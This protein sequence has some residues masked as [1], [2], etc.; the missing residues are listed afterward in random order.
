MPCTVGLI[1]YRK[2]KLKYKP[3][4]VLFDSGT[5][6]SIVLKEFVSKLQLSKDSRVEWETKGG[7]FI[8]EGTCTTTFSFPEFKNWKGIEWQLHVDSMTKAKDS[9]YDMIIGGDLM[10]ELGLDIKYSTH[11]VQWDQHEISMKEQGAIDKLDVNDILFEENFE[12]TVNRKLVK[13]LDNDYAKADLQS[14]VNECHYLS[15][16][17]K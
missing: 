16:Q 14:V 15:T 10:S 7:I 12:S 5:T 2:G 13:L 6:K 9:H 17:E 8:T 4:R 3:L 11:T 1:N